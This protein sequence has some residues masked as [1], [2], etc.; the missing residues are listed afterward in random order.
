LKQ[1]HEDRKYIIKKCAKIKMF[2]RTVRIY[3]ETKRK[4][5]IPGTI[6]EI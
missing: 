6:A 2:G 1:N 4:N 3:E 5:R